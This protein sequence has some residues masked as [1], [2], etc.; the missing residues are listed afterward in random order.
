MTAAI[1]LS[2]LVAVGAPQQ[3]SPPR[4]IA[5]VPTTGTASIRG[6]VTSA[7]EQ[8]RPIRRALVTVTNGAVARNVTTDDKGAFVVAELPAG[9]FAVSAAK[10]GYLP[11][12]FG[13]KR[14]GSPGTLVAIE[15][16]QTAD[17]PM[18]MTLGGVISGT[19][20]DGRGRPRVGIHVAAI[21]PPPP[22]VAWDTGGAT[23]IVT[24]DD[25]G[26]YRLG[27]LAPEN[28]LIVAL[29]ASP[30]R[31]AVDRRP[32]EEND[33][34]LAKLA[35]R[36]PGQ[37]IIVDSPRRND[38]GTPVSAGT[39]TVAP[40]FYPGVPF[41]R[42]ASRVTVAA[43]Q[44]VQ[45]IDFIF[46]PVPTGSIE[47][48]LQAPIRDISGVDMSL[49]IDG[50]VFGFG[51][52]SRPILT[53]PTDAPERFRYD[54]VTEGS[55]RIMAR[56]RVTPSG[57]MVRSLNSGVGQVTGGGFATPA[58]TEAADS[59]YAA[60]DVDVTRGNVANVS[61]SLSPGAIFSGTI[62]IDAAAPG[63]APDLSAARFRLSPQRGTSMSATD[64]TSIGDTFQ[65]I[66][67]QLRQDDGSVVIRG[68]P[69][70]EFNI[71]AALNSPT[72]RAWWLR[73]AML[74]ARDLLDGPV[75]VNA[76]DTISAV[77]LTLSNR[78]SELK[79]ALTTADGCA[80]AEYFVAV[81]P[82]DP[83][84]WIPRT[85]R[86]RNIRPSSD[87]AF[88]FKDLPDG[89]YILAALGDAADSDFDDPAFLA[90]VAPAG[91]IVRVV[92]GQTTVQNLRIGIR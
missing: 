4:D 70:G 92:D 84:G 41:W 24:T 86:V 45:G 31:G 54:N 9:R 58:G 57:D 89:D 88:S 17:A 74:N 32:V 7:D 79:G 63:D 19:I 29:S 52:G 27:G 18:T 20:R 91:V 73:S 6:V 65:S 75:A 71:V 50:P 60:V 83:Q 90:A 46:S 35:A 13:E 43:G 47:G 37:P 12:T 48:V 33:E 39:G 55:Y 67:Y 59:Y 64:N 62:R 36:Q 38:A 22:G 81:L 21:L 68:I 56:A 82:K 30:I 42:T 69:P 61:V 28:Y 1:A 15:A 78:H 53:R 10:P 44:D 49:I 5:T 80:A 3:A 26:A 23:V 77:V 40:L 8:R 11:A 85:R 2:L 66:P 14:R 25:S 87:G 34:L 72:S 51:I 16:G 76:G